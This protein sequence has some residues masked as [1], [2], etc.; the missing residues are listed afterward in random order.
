MNH[1]GKPKKG[2]IALVSAGH[3]INDTYMGF[4]AVLL[5]F[6]VTRWEIS[7]T[8]AGVLVTAFLSASYFGQPVFGWF[9]DRLGGRLLLAGGPLVSA[10]FIGTLGVLPSYG[11]AVPWVIIAGVG[12]AA[13]HPPAAG[14]AHRAGGNRRALGMSIFLMAG[15]LGVA[16][17]PIEILAV[18]TRF[19]LKFSGLT[20]IPGVV[21]SFLLFKYADLGAAPKTMENCPSQFSDLARARGTLSGLWAIVVLRNFTYAAFSSFLPL[22]LQQRGLSAWAG[23]TVLSAFLAT[24][25]VGGVLGG[26]LS[27]RFD[28]RAIIALTMVAATV[29]L[30]LFLGARGPS[31]MV[32]LIFGGFFL[33][34]SG[35]INVVISQEMFPEHAGLMAS[36]MMGFAYGVGSVGIV[37]VGAVADRLGI[38]ATL[39][40][41]VAVP[42]IAAWLG[43]RLPRD[44]AR[45]KRSISEAHPLS[46]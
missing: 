6:F 5:P 39:S 42:L 19:G 22:M 20:V 24:G 1:T 13:F 10:C 26:Y 28:R 25:A 32:F 2:Q 43:S 18:V 29:L 16:L 3:L 4:I 15:F 23:G 12:A 46:P 31:G 7:L 30:G 45:P 17:G 11:W 33:M 8:E 44:A 9:S 27:D 37:V 14:V 34:M 38:P 21:A 36:L 35:P 41:A 40:G